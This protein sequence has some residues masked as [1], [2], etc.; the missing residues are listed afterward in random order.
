MMKRMSGSRT[1]V[2]Y[3]CLFFWN[4]S[5]LFC[6]RSS[7]KK[8][9]R[10]DEKWRTEAMRTYSFGESITRP[11]LIDNA[12]AEKPSHFQ[13]QLSLHNRIV[14]LGRR[15]KAGHHALAPSASITERCQP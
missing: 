9:N 6:A 7:R 3:R 2:S 1:C 15:D 12:A 8:S 10:S 4:Q 14:R 13:K 5:R 11:R